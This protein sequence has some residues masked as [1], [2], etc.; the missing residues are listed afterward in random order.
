MNAG[1]V[2]AVM[3]ADPI[4]VSTKTSFKDIAELLTGNGISAV[5]VLDKTGTLVGVVSEADLLPHLWEDRKPRWRDRRPA[6]KATA[7]VAMDLMT[8]PA[9]TIDAEATL[10]TAA[11]SGP[12]GSAWRCGPAS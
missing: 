10:A 11:A 5:G 3:T 8:S 1:M 9:V 12:T 6:R 7:C 4:T 2:S